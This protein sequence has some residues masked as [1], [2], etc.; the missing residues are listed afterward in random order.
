[1]RAFARTQ[2]LAIQAA[3]FRVR[4]LVEIR[5]PLDELGYALRA[6]GNQR[7]GGGA[8]DYPVAGIHGVFEVQGNVFLALHSD[9]N[10][11]LRVVRVRF[12]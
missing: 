4:G 5:A 11:A 2:E 1:M 6:F 8:V 12:R 7:L 9:G 10:A 3:A